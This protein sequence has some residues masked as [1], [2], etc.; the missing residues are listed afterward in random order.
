MAT[1]LRHVRAEDPDV[2]TRRV[3][4]FEVS[5][6]YAVAGSNANATASVPSSSVPATNVVMR[7][8]IP[9]CTA[10]GIGLDVDE[11]PFTDAAAVEVDQRRHVRGGHAGH[12]AVHDRE[13]ADLARG[14]QLAALE[15]GAAA[16]WRRR[17]VGR[18][19][20]R[21]SR[22]PPT[23]QVRRAVVERRGSRRSGSACPF[24]T[25]Y[26]GSH[27]SAVRQSQDNAS[28]A[29]LADAPGLGPGPARGGSSSLPARTP[30]AAWSVF[31][32]L[33]AAGITR[34]PCSHSGR[35]GS[36]VGA[37]TPRAARAPVPRAT[38]PAPTQQRIL[39]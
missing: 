25:S 8:G 3:A 30:A 15:L 14:R 13:R 35:R 11:L 23:H 26:V 9:S 16:P 2:V 19:R 29:E 36:S 27:G 5:H 31:A 6:L 34:Q 28:V 24:R 38:S 32:G 37:T 1:E 4:S 10:S 17:C 7:T 12:G 21:P 20:A 22:P 39:R 18:S 33:I